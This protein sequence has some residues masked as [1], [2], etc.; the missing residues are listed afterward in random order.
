[1]GGRA[2]P[3][4]TVGDASTTGVFHAYLGLACIGYGNRTNVVCRTMDKVSI[5][6]H[7]TE[8]RQC[9][10]VTNLYLIGM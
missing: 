1:M 4:R 2:R 10:H 3:G 7:G 8:A 6:G 5:C 9:S